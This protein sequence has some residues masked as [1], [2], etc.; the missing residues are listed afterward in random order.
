MIISHYNA[1]VKDNF[2]MFDI[3]EIKERR[4]SLGLTQEDVAQWLEIK[5]STWAKKEKGTIPVTTKEYQLVVEGLDRTLQKL[6]KQKEVVPP[7]GILNSECVET[8][9]RN[10]GVIYES[11][12][13]PA[14]NSL[15]CHIENLVSMLVG[16]GQMQDVIE[17]LNTIQ[18]DL[19]AIKAERA[20]YHERL[21]RIEELLKTEGLE[22][23]A[24]IEA[25]QGETAAK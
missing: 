7:C 6:E 22:E 17:R 19:N 9:C 3:K 20:R 1:L 10:V 4:K 11:G 2:V 14:I 15:V 16:R 8:I 18:T 23:K 21:D 13:Q 24:V 5:R 25:K 12:S